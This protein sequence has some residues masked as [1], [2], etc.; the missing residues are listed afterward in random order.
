MWNGFVEHL[1]VVAERPRVPTRASTGSDCRRSVVAS[2]S[3]D[4]QVASGQPAL[5][6]GEDER[7][8]H[9]WRIAPADLEGF[10]WLASLTRTEAL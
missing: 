5:D 3:G 9:E 10:A 2:D 7:E 4:V 1:L 8:R 6:G